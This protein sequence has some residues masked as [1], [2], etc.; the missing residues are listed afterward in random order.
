MPTPKVKAFYLIS[1]SPYVS[2][3]VELSLSETA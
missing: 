2:I 1:W 3:R